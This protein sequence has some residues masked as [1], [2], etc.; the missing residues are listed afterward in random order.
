MDDLKPWHNIFNPLEYTIKKDSKHE[1]GTEVSSILPSEGEIRLLGNRHRQCMY[2]TIGMNIF[3]NISLGV[4]Y[5]VTDM[6]KQVSD[7]YLPC[8]EPIDAMYRCYTENKYGV[9]LHNSPKFTEPFRN[10]F[11]NCLFAPP[12]RMD[13]C[14]H[15]FSDVIRAIYRSKD[16]KL[17]DFF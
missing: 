14:M 6:R 15:H 1:F 4:D 17:C 9:S 8:K 13:V 10:S 2:Y 7:N 11:F 16:S 3:P 5:C 12:N